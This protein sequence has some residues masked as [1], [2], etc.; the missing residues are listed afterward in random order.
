[1]YAVLKLFPRDDD[2]VNAA[3]NNMKPGSSTL[4]SRL[5]VK[6]LKLKHQMKKLRY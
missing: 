6:L 2:S 3:K 4:Q 1:M 5:Q